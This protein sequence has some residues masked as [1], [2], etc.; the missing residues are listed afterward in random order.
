MEDVKWWHRY[1]PT[2]NEISLISTETRS[3]PD[4]IIASD[5][6][7]VGCGMVAEGGHVRV[8][9]SARRAPQA[10]YHRARRAARPST[11]ALI[12]S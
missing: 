1:R 10:E 3:E 5:D 11:G 4:K 6:C 9:S 8:P 2:F 12:S 7:L